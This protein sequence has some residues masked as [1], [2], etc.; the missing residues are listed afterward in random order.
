MTYIVGWAVNI[1]FS[2][3]HAPFPETE[4]LACCRKMDS[5]WILR[6]RYLEAFRALQYPGT[7]ISI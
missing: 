4:T 5:L 3:S 1:A 2:S 6:R 7:L